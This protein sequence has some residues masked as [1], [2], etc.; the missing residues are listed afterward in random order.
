[1]SNVTLYT[2]FCRLPSASAAELHAGTAASTG[3]ELDDLSPQ[4]RQAGGCATLP[5]AVLLG[6]IRQTQMLATAIG[7]RAKERTSVHLVTA[8]L[9]PAMGAVMSHRG[10]AVPRHAARRTGQAGKAGCCA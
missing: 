9:D 10:E 5:N 6:W 4:I 8:C 1:M 7:E 2:H 3:A